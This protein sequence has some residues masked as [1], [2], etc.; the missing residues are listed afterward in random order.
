[1]LENATKTIQLPDVDTDTFD[2][3]CIIWRH[4]KLMLASFSNLCNLYE[5]ADR[6]LISNLRDDCVQKLVQSAEA[7]NILELLELADRHSDK[8][9]QNELYK[10]FF[11]KKRTSIMHCKMTLLL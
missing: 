10:F 9:L 11:K 8:T 1:M 3:F 5:M 2:S 7:Q 4:I 6:F